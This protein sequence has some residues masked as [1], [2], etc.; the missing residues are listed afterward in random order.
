M[1]SKRL[2]QTDLD[3]IIQ[4]CSQ[5]SDR[6]RAGSPGDE[7]HCL[8]LFRRAVEENDQNAWNAIHAQYR[9]LVARW[10]GPHHDSDALIASTFERF[11]HALRGVRLSRRFDHVG[12]L[13]SY[14]RKCALCVQLDLE[15]EKKKR[16][17]ERPLNEAITLSTDT[18]DG[19]VLDNV[20]RDTLQASV[21]RWLQ[22]HLQD[23]QER[24]VIFLS[25]SL[26]LKPAEIARRHPTLFANARAVRRVKERVLKRLRRRAGE[27]TTQI[28]D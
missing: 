1:S 16:D 5:E 6:F 4:G 7:G 18:I 9:H 12:A 23:E 14:L 28:K 3:A 19:L 11:W 13:L 15:R 26:D 17:C 20:A 24:R 10:I 25:Y 21:L 8:E 27:L 22:A 2:R